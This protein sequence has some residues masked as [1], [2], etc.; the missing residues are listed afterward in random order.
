MKFGGLNL[1]V[2]ARHVLF[3][4]NNKLR[5]KALNFTCQDISNNQLSP[6]VFEIDLDE[7]TP[8]HSNGADVALILIGWN[9]SLLKNK[10]TPQHKGVHKRKRDIFISKEGVMGPENSAKGKLVSVGEGTTRLFNEIGIGN[11]V[12]IVGYPI[13]LGLDTS[14]QLDHKRPLLRKGIIAG[15]N[16][17]QRTIIL[18]CPVYFGNSGGP[19]IEYDNTDR[20]FYIIGVVSQYVPFVN[21]WANVRERYINVELTNSGYCV[22]EPMDAV[23]D[24]IDEKYANEAKVDES[25]LPQDIQDMIGELR[26]NLGN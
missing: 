15:I 1:I 23:F 9:I 22:V 13:S 19:V 11:D 21:K 25:V 26:K 5:C 8:V 7:I 10:I 17:E 12:F 20:C 16:Q 6:V 2:T 4:E 24:L 14:G 3:D 18:D